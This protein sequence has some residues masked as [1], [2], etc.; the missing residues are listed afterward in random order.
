MSQ[1]VLNLTGIK[2]MGDWSIISWTLIIVVLLMADRFLVRRGRIEL[3]ELSGAGF[4]EQANPKRPQAK[5]LFYR[6]HI[7]FRAYPPLIFSRVTYTIRDLN[8]PTTV[9]NGKS[10]TLDFSMRGHNQEYLLIR[11]DLLA[12]GAWVA[13]VRV[14]SL[15]CRINPLYKIFPLASHM[16]KEVMIA[17]PTDH[18]DAHNEQH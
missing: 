8:C 9:V 5:E 2:K 15:G 7:A 17:L 14:E 10:R 16:R 6:L 13:D 1:I 3:T 18:Q 4:V 12:T 11:T